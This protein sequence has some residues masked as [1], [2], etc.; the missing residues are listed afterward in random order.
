MTKGVGV[1]VGVGDADGVEGGVENVPSEKLL[2]FAWRLRLLTI[3]SMSP[4]IPTLAPTESFIGT[5]MTG[6]VD[7]DEGCY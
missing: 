3:G 6:V 2:L 7:K 4:F 5:F 1:G